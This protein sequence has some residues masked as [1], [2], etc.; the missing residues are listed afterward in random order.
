M[1]KN[2]KQKRKRKKKT[3]PNKKGQDLFHKE[4]QAGSEEKGNLWSRFLVF[5]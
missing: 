2:K 1:S 3:T 5:I 4:S